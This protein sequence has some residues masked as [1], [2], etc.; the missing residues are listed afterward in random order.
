ML[1]IVMEPVGWSTD[2]FKLIDEDS[3]SESESDS[4]DDEEEL[5]VTKGYSKDKDRYK[6]ILSED[7][8]LPE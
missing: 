3:E 2:E 7:E 6:K 8:L 5:Q 4:D 1:L